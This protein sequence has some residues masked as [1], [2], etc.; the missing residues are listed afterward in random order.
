MTVTS[1]REEI[2]RIYKT[3]IR[4]GVGEIYPIEMAMVLL[5]HASL[6]NDSWAEF[7][8]KVLSQVLMYFAKKGQK[9]KILQCFQETEIWSG[10]ISVMMEQE[11]N[12]I[13]ESIFPDE[14][15]SI[16]SLQ[17]E[18]ITHL[19]AGVGEITEIQEHDFFS[20]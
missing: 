11:F 1:F 19:F 13:L 14:M 16:K 4:I 17:Q 6:D 12:K 20:I 7:G 3:F 10:K 18:K 5:A 2:L 15:W 9:D 8:R